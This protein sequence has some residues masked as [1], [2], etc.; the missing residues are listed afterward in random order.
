MKAKLNILDTLLWLGSISKNAI[1]YSEVDMLIITILE[2]E[3]LETIPQEEFGKTVKELLPFAC[4]VPIEELKGFEVNQAKLWQKVAASE[5]YK[6]LR[7]LDAV[8]EKIEDAKGA[9]Q[10]AAALFQDGGEYYLVYRGTD[11]SLTGW[12]EDFNMAVDDEIPSEKR[13][14][15]GLERVTSNLDSLHILGHS[16]G[17]TLALYAAMKASDETFSKIK[18]LYI[19][20]APGLPDS[21]I[22]EERWKEIQSITHSFIPSSSVIGMLF[23][24][25][26]YSTVVKS[27]SLGLMQ[28]DAFTWVLSGGKF[29][30]QPSITS[31]SRKIDNTVKNFIARLDRNERET[32]VEVLYKILKATDEENVWL[33]PEAAAKRFPEI[34]KAV[35]SLTDDEKKTLTSILLTLE[36][37]RRETRRR[38]RDEWK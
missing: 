14:L 11:E 31:R 28:H 33:M 7:L 22:D 10:Y 23:N 25:T 18:D 21:L 37:A 3:K 5:R 19:F 13:A 29:V 24:T 17:G 15:E 20:D 27:S 34:K 6:D 35:E 30:T 4:P 38:N 26:E 36:E 9:E 2:Y 8:G 12:K 16:K 32:L 1:P